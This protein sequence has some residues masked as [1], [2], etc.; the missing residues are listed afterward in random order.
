MRQQR[1][2]T[3]VEIA[4]VLVIIGLL[5]GGVLKGQE[6]IASARVRSL[7]DQQGAIQAAYF[8]FQDRYG[9]I[10]GDMAQATADEAI[11]ADIT[12]GGNS[13]GRLEE[14]ADGNWGELN[15]VWE[16]LSKAEFIK[17]SYQGSTEA[18]AAGNQDV[19]PNNVYG[20]PTILAF[21]DGYADTSGTP[22]AR[23]VLHI[24]GNTPV[25]ISRQLDVKLDDG[26]P[27]TGALRNASENGSPAVF[28]SGQDCVDGTD[29]A[30]WDVEANVQLCN[31]SYL[32]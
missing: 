20:S 4:V 21:H 22:A 31:P 17:G 9:A 30:I 14:P 11:A 16:H 15:A 28:E 23:L 13:N 5:L 26:Q 1:G 10:P 18:P 29:P 24:G 12:T 32:F 8:G 19:S 3:L 6:L 27:E 2:F 7:A 25:D